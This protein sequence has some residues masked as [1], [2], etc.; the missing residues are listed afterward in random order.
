MAPLYHMEVSGYD[1]IR[2]LL[3]VEANIGSVAVSVG[4][5]VVTPG[6]LLRQS[7]YVKTD[8]SS[9]VEPTGMSMNETKN[10]CMT[11]P[12]DSG[13]RFGPLIAT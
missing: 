5:T 12:V 1:I 6:Q 8:S 9:E 11:L 10:H 13:R 7:V 4:R 3:D 2:L